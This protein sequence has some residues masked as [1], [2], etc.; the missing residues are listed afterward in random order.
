MVVAAM[1]G[2]GYQHGDGGRGERLGLGFHFGR[3]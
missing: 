3:W 2:G 1:E